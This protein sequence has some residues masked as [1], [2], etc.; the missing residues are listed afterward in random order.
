MSHVEKLFD[1]LLGL[2]KLERS[3][4][5]HL[6]EHPGECCQELAA[7]EAKDRTVIQKALK[8]LFDK[9]WIERAESDRGKLTYKPLPAVQMRELLLQRIEETRQHMVDVVK[10]AF[11]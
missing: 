10:Q 2:T 4:F 9:G 11:H 6:L 8:K 1:C 7:R 5:I 3:I